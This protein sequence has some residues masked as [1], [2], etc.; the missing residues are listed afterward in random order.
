VQIDV[1]QLMAG[2]L[3][4][5]LESQAQMR[6]KA[7]D[8][9]MW[10][11]VIGACGALPLLA[12]VWFGPQLP[13]D[14]K[15]IASAILVLGISAWG[16]APIN[17]AKRTIKVGINSAIARSLGISYEHEVS[18]G[19]EF[20]AARTY[21]LLPNHDRDSCEDRWF[22]NL[23]GHRF[24]LY[25][26][27]LEER[28]GSGKRRRWVTVFRGALIDMSF[29]RPFHSTTLLQRAGKHKKWFGLG[30]AKDHVSFK[31]HRLDFV[32]Q[33]HPDFEDVFDVYSDDQVE[34]RV[35]VH[36]S[37]IEHLLELEKAFKGDAVRALFH[38][39]E[40]IIAVESGKLFESG[41]M[42]ASRDRERAEG[43]AKQF[44]ALAGLA[45]A[46]NQT[47]RGQALRPANGEVANGEEASSAQPQSSDAS[48]GRDRGVRAARDAIGVAGFVGRRGFGRKGL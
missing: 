40:V 45:L 20:H 44:S 23:E 48:D 25:E 6:A 4:D 11:F 30:S 35:I 27:H 26:A 9:A 15:G 7:M 18:P 43:A 41:A 39:G 28:R 32:D 29:G 14:W 10:R 5:W 3:G 19:S 42:D 24:N 22:G 37:Y 12:F 46:I 13:F 16:Y 33:V 47:E 21:G 17:Q 34:A 2:D 38:E 8:K 1:N 31:G 36:P